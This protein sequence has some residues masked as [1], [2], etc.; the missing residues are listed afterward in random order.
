[1]NALL[2]RQLRRLGLDPGSPP[3]DPEVWRRLL[4]R[5]GRSY[6]DAEQNRYLLERSLRISSQEMAEVLEALRRTSAAR[7]AEQE[8][9]LRAVVDS[10][11]D[12]LC[13]LDLEGRIEFANDAAAAML[14]AA[15]DDLIGSRLLG[16][17]RFW[18]DDPAGPIS[19]DRILRIGKGGHRF[20]DDTALLYGT[21]AEPRPVS[22]VLS[23][24]GM[25]G[26]VRGL[27]FVFRDLTERHRT[28]QAIRRSE[29][30]YRTLFHTIP[31]AVYEE[32]FSAVAEWLGELRSSGVVDL[33]AHLERHPDDLLTAVG[34][35]E[36]ND[37]NPAVV[38]L[39]EADHRE[40]LFG[41]IRPEL[42]TEET[43]ASMREQLL[44]IWEGRDSV[45]LELTGTTLRG[46]RLD[47]IFHWSA[48]RVQGRQD[49]SKVL[50]AMTDI[51][52]R[53][54]IEDQLADLLRSKDD[55][56][57]AVSH[58]LR[59]PLTA[60]YGNSLVLQQQWGDLDTA[61]RLALVRDIATESREL[62]NIVEDLLVAARSDIG[63]LSIGFEPVDLSTEVAAAVGS[64]RGQRPGQSITSEGVA[65]VALAD[66]LRLRQI[67][68]NLLSNAIRYGGDAIRVCAEQQDGRVLIQVR[69]NG[70]GIPED[71]QEQVFHAY[72]RAHSRPGVPGSVGIGLT[73]SRQ[74]AVLMGG[75]LAYYRDRGETVFEVAL[76]AAFD[77]GDPRAVGNLRGR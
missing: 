36:V 14:A 46:N 5:V 15:E 51:T 58:E 65:A 20:S 69:D 10:L 13:T 61:E 12:G 1:M 28:L 68:R 70:D 44:A 27:V 66:P 48:A 30:H 57:A 64:Q 71:E 55:L 39:V 75:D 41:R 72:H 76:A 40:Q 43:L 31:I 42:F 2:A 8:T 16:R 67:L 3:S 47:A 62:T 77:A 6:D 19:S 25:R 26:G 24:I 74:L 11:G 73:V 38:T 56:I 34:L 17:F 18:P 50:V 35:I 33:R 32:D 63:S 53:K 23:P 49:L 7:E 9:R 29:Q 37:V 22:C 21:G 52:E 45:H 4:E 60:V 59:T 54:E